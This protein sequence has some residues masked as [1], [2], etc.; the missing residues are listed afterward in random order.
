[1]APVLIIYTLE[2]KFPKKEIIQASNICFLFGKIVQIAL[3]AFASAFTVNEL[4][5]SIMT[6]ISVL[7]GFIY[8]Y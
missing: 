7:I 3:F 6:L 2:S 4:T 1:M 8:W 5:L